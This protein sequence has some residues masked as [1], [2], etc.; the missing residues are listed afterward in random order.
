MPAQR[1]Q[2]GSDFADAFSTIGSDTTCN[3]F[4]Q[5]QGQRVYTINGEAVVPY[6]PAG[7]R[8]CAT[9]SMRRRLVDVDAVTQVS[10]AIENGCVFP[11]F[12][13]ADLGPVL[14]QFMAEPM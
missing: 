12:S 7:G 6:R 9:I 3:G 5:G 13:A 14:Q 4:W 8:R 1:S 11:L 2:I 10:L